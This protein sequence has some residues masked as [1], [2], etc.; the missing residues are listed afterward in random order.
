[1]VAKIVKD[2]LH[3]SAPELAEKVVPYRAGYTPEQRRELE[4]RL[5][6]GEMLAVITTNAL[7]LGIDIGALDAAV[8]VDVPG[9]RRVA[10]ADVGPRGSPR[11]G[12]RG[13][14]RRRGRAG[15]V[16]LPPPRRVPRPAGGVGDPRPRVRGDPHRPPALRR[17]RGP[18]RP[19]DRRRRLR[20]AGARALRAPRRPRRAGASAGAVHAA[21]CRGVPGRRAS[22]CA[23]PRRTSSR[24]S[25]RASGEMLGTVEA[26]ART[27]PSTTARST[28]T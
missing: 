1:M 10:A 23:A 14:R 3:D 9:D 4:A 22:R 15:P 8:C 27:R 7:E 26:A 17:A 20:P 13:L 6:G 16:L 24:S 28:C 25:R 11:P 19:A 12:A 2:Q 5:M 18:D 21:P